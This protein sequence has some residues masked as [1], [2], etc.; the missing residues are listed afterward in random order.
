M[1]VL[2]LLLPAL[3]LVCVVRDAA[4]RV[5]VVDNRSAGGG[6]GTY[7][8]PF[9]SFSE[10]Q[11]GSAPSDIIYVAEGI[12]AYEESLTLKRGQ[13]LIG[14][15]YGLDAARVEFKAAFTEPSQ[16]A[17]QGPGPLIHGGVFAAGDN[18]IAGCT[19][20]PDVGVGIGIFSPQGKIDIRKVFIRPG[21]RAT[22]ISI[23]LC[24][25]PITI[26]GGGITAESGNGLF[27][28]G[29][30]GDITVDH[31][32]ITGNFASAL[33]VRGRSTG[34]VAFGSAAQLKIYDAFR[35]A[36]TIADNDVAVT[37]DSPMQIATRGGR[38]LVVTKSNRVTIA[39]VSRID[40]INATAL[41]LHDAALDATFDHISAAGVAPGTLREGII[42]DKSRGRLT[43]TGNETNEPA[44]G[45]TIRNAQAYGLRIVQSTGMR[46]A[47]IDIIDSGHAATKCPADIAAQTNVRCAAG[48]NLRHLAE[49]KFSN[50]RIT[51]GAVGLNT[52][53]L[54]N[55]SF[56]NIDIRN[57][58]ATA[59]DAAVL[60]QESAGTITLTRCNIAD[61][62]GGQ[63][64]IEQRFNAVNFVIDRC[65]VSA[66]QRP[67]ASAA[68]FSIRVAGAGAANVRIDSTNFRENVGSAI[69]VEAK[70]TSSVSIA[71]DQ[72]S[73]QSLGASF[74][75]LSAHQTASARLAIHNT[76]VIAPGSNR[77]LVAVTLT[78]A[79]RAC[80]DLS[81]NELVG[82][83]P[84]PPLSVPTC[85]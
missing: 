77:P 44:S 58:G 55:V 25:V 11:R 56:D 42:I 4:A 78:D 12:G 83:V 70:D 47:N 34:R 45:G 27:I 29:G 19:I 9:K 8:R 73:A 85:Q 76:R 74:L 84:T 13:M 20:A 81:N 79:A 23:Q 5:V 43:I 50:F 18:V 67:M 14:D 32:P 59:T 72:S 26:D 28:D 31:F 80:A 66:P 15:A 49:S 22:A 61:G 21:A 10:A 68:L 64:A 41:E 69:D 57:T 52:N 2:R 6:D 48:M 36:V 24:E 16:P 30:R 82:G 75:D 53:N 35:D 7:E 63:F 71:I 17:S 60:M 40:A 54:R 65:T 3:L 46:V 37:F 1:P 51:G 33:V 38:G 62:S 39:G